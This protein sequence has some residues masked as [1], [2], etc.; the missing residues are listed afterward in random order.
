[1]ASQWRVSVSLPKRSRAKGDSPWTTAMRTLRSRIGSDIKISQTPKGVFLYAT[2]ADAAM[3]AEQVVCDVLAE[4]DVSAGVRRDQWNPI[5]QSWTSH[6]DLMNAERKKSIATGRA[7]WQVRV[8]SLSHRELK[9]LARRL[10][11]EGLSV[12]LRWR[13]L[14]AGA[15]CEDDAHALADQIRGYSSARTRIRVQPGVYDVR[16]PARW[17]LYPPA[18][19]NGWWSRWLAAPRPANVGCW[20]P[21]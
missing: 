17:G 3:Q 8:A 19:I 2:S 7:A 16:L 20:R 13:Y 9:A 4:H 21:D 12:A 15:G 1:M 14:I 5:N 11:A 18:P 10:E 6:E